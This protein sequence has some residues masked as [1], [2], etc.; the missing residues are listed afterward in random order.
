MPRKKVLERALFFVYVDFFSYFCTLLKGIEVTK[1]R[2]I[3][4]IVCLMLNMSLSARVHTT[5][6]YGYVTDADNKGIELVNIAVMSGSDMQVG[7]TTNR[8]GYYTLMVEMADTVEVVYS[9]IGYTTIRQQLFTDEEVI[10]IN[11]MLPDDAV[12]MDELEVKGI[13][14]QTGTMERQSAEIVRVMPDASGGSIESLLITFAGV[15]QNNELSS[16]YNVRGGSFDEN[17]VYVNGIEVH[18]PLLIRSGQQEGLSFVNPEMVQNVGFSAGGFDAMYGDKMSSVLDIEYK[19]PTRFEA[20]MNISLLGAGVYVG[21]G[22]SSFSQMHGIRYKTNR[23]MLGGLKTTGNYDPN[24]VDYQ[25]QLTWR[26]GKK[27]PSSRNRWEMRFLG[28]VS[29]N[30]YRFKPDSLTESFGTMQ[31]SQNLSIWYEGQEKDRFLTVFG[32]L[33]AHG[34]VKVNNGSIGVDVNLSGFYTNEQENFDI[35][36]EYVLS[37]GGSSRSD[38]SGEVSTGQSAS[39]LGTGVYHEHA[40]N[41]L[42]AGV[43]TVAHSGEWTNRDA[44]NSLRW[45]L[46]AQAELI[47]DRISEWEWRDSAGYSMPNAAKQM[48]L[49]YSMRGENS[50]H[51]A[52]LQAYVQN[53]HRFVTEACRINLTVG[54]RLN[55]WTFTG[56][57]LPSP[58]AGVEFIPGWKRNVV[59]R[60]ATGLYYQAP[61]YK[62]VRDTL[63]TDGI[64]R[65]HLNSDI[66]AQRSVHA[67]FGTDYY[68]RAWGRAFKL[69]GEA[70]YKYID[71]MESY[72]VDNVRVR[73]SGKNDAT[74]YAAGLDLKLYGELVP[75]ADSW[76]SFSTMTARH[77]MNDHPEYGWLHS[78][79]EQRYSVSMLFQDYIPR[80]PQL[81]FHIKFIW[82]EGLPFSAP[83]NIAAQGRMRDYRRIDLG[84]TYSFNA[85]TARFMRRPSARHVKEWALQLEVFNIVDWKNVNGYFWATDAYGQQWASPNY[86]TGRMFNF[87]IRV[88]LQ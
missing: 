34:Q 43:I 85:K 7:T 72:T 29:L 48:N 31:Q 81:L 4:T 74:G 40:R 27:Q 32:A 28:N 21:H 20:S 62:E 38:V 19:R 61:F 45:G 60:L 53:T 41:R 25:T 75:G 16:Q 66:K 22:D 9:M 69:S 67:L 18:R 54:A 59:F 86:L 84:A 68:F 79:Q 30:D 70:Y 14:Q 11:V 15:S 47:R 56:E 6:V 63:T 83:R 10:N 12:M 37:A 82:S 71:R 33:G 36:G 39:V 87:K 3:L 52:R 57:V 23:Y 64:T 26:V 1:C 77:K 88:D 8:N 46:S 73:Y 58:R 17:S 51:S 78:P 65:I 5:R 44:S 76:I 35:S 49:Y 50:M 55:Y 13:R 80:L 42:S 24:F 2:V